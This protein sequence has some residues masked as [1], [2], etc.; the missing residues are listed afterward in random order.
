MGQE[1]AAPQEED[2]SQDVWDK[3]TADKRRRLRL[4]GVTD[5]ARTAPVAL[6]LHIKS[7]HSFLPEDLQRAAEDAAEKEKRVGQNPKND[8]CSLCR[9]PF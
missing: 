7:S 9:C 4:T 8:G 5:P 2:F 3:T 1:V 6:D